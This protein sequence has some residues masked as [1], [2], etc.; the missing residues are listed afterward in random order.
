MLNVFIFYS[1]WY[2]ITFV[3]P[4]RMGNVVLVCLIINQLNKLASNE[5][6]CMQTELT[7]NNENI[8]SNKTVMDRIYVSTHPQRSAA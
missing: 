4:Q 3:L 7:V 2:L 1:L 6:K 5:T 8:F